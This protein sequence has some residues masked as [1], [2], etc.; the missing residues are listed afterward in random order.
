MNHR[1]P[2]RKMRTAKKAHSLLGLLAG[3]LLWVRSKPKAK[4]TPSDLRRAEFKTS[5]QRLG[6]RF[7]ES[8]RDVFRFRWI[9]MAGKDS[10]T[11]E[12]QSGNGEDVQPDR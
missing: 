1:L 6:I 8:I 5:T 4:I 11:T 10:K 12:S 9:R 2:D 7:V 3:W